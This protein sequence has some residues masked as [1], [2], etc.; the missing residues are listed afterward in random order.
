MPDV[1]FEAEP[2]LP[3]R[4][5]DLR[6]FATVDGAELI[7]CRVANEVFGDWFGISQ[8]TPQVISALLPRL[9]YAFRRM[10]ACSDSQ[11]WV[12]GNVSRREFVLTSENVRS[13]YPIK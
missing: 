3:D 4:L 2:L 8:P 6:L 5:H 13:Y 12:D 10:V 11:I 7:R 1:T 9:E